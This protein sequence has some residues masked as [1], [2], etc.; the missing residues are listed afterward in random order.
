MKNKQIFFLI[1]WCFISFYFSEA[2]NIDINLKD[3]LN[4]NTA[5]DT[6]DNVCQIDFI[7]EGE[8]PCKELYQQDW[9]SEHIKYSDTKIFLKE[10]MTISLL[11]EEHP[12]FVMPC[13]GK[14]CSD[15]GW[16]KNHFHS[17][18]DIKQNLNDSIYACFD[19]V[20]RMAKSYYG[21]GNLVVIRHYN[22]L[23]TVYAHLNKIKVKENQ[24]I[25]AG[26]L[27][28]LAGRTGRTTTEHLHFEVRFLYKTYNPRYFI[29]FDKKKL[30]V[31]KY[32]FKA[33]ANTDSQSAI[34]SNSTKSLQSEQEQQTYHKVV[35][36]DTLYSIAKRYHTTISNLCDINHLD[37][38]GI[39]SLG[40]KIK[41]K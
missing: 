28:G 18:V 20:V 30:A 15:Y 3:S 14:I 26:D 17:G 9:F 27:V 37:K 22:G 25:K 12:D 34:T 13:L 35:K 33:K 5:I 21:Y 4:R 40:Q 24:K 39:L 29:D 36:G 31:S 6:A 16:R 10:D 38:E 1:F 19:G 7:R 32:V 2:Q 41:L 11:S 8:F 23:E